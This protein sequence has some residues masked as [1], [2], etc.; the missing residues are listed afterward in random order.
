M[1]KNLLENLSLQ[2]NKELYSAYLY[3]AMSIYFLEINMEGFAKVIK[4][5]IKEELNHAKKIYNYLLSR[6]EEII[7]NDIKAPDTNWINPY[8]AIKSALEHEKTITNDIKHLYEMSKETKDYA[9]EV[10]LQW[11]IEEQVEEES[12][13]RCLLDKIEQ[14][15]NLGCEIIHIDRNLKLDEEYIE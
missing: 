2:I 9:T 6:D 4:N 5:Q 11:F 15:K 1:D 10:F 7:L 12:K 3:F 13:F 14:T 8:D